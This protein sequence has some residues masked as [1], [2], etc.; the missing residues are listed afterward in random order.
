MVEI[1]KQIVG[2]EGLYEVSNLGNVKSLP[3]KWITGKGGMQSHNG[4][5]LKSSSKT[6]YALVYLCKDSKAKTVKVHQLVAMAFLNHVPCGMKLVIDHIDDNRLNNKSDNLQIV[7][8]RFNSYKTQGKGTSKFKGV[9]WNKG[10]NKW[11]AQIRVKGSIRYLGLFINEKDAHLAYQNKIKE[12]KILT[13]I[14][15][16]QSE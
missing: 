15:L 5:I 13:Q 11:T 9:C 14:I 3:R 12:I 16:K 2:Y 6:K 4:K 8:A 10:A 1:W 7:T